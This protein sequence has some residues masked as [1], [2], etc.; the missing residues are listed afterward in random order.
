MAG[1][2]VFGVIAGVAML[3]AEK[4]VTVLGFLDVMLE[5]GVVSEDERVWDVDCV[6]VIVTE[7]E[8]VIA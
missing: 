6:P 1:V 3:L 2:G 5:K 8:W 7:L 4:F